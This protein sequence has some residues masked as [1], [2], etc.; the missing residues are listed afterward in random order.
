M[1]E[2]EDPVLELVSEFHVELMVIRAGPRAS[3]EMSSMV[4]T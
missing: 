2:P 1:N 3:Y 4:Q